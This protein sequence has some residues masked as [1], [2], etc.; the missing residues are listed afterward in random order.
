MGT[1][2]TFKV[3]AVISKWIDG[4]HGPYGFAEIDS[5]D[6]PA[7]SA[8]CSYKVK[9]LTPPLGVKFLCHIVPKGSRW[10]VGELLVELLSADVKSLAGEIGYYSGKGKLKEWSKGRGPCPPPRCRH[11]GSIWTVFGKFILQTSIK[12]RPSSSTLFATAMDI[13]DTR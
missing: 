13:M 3:E 6:L 10:R 11:S 5:P 9:G 8:L 12:T 1:G 7:Q 4:K 2:D